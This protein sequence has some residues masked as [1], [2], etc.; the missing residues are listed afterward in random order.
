[1]NARGGS[2]APSTPC[3]QLSSVKELES[4]KQ[5]CAKGW[6]AF[7]NRASGIIKAIWLYLWLAFRYNLI[8][9]HGNRLLQYRL[10]LADQNQDM[11]E[12]ALQDV[13]FTKSCHR[14][15]MISNTTEGSG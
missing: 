6:S 13:N 7:K 3:E 12:T 10:A 8:G 14:P 2:H 4:L 5:L 9:D 11:P 1:V 15:D